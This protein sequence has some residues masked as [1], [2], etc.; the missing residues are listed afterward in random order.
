ML[1]SIIIPVY[2]AEKYLEECLNSFYQQDIPQ[3]EYEVICVND[4][5]T[6]GSSIILDEFALKYTNLKIINKDNGGVASSRNEGLLSARGKYVW[7]VDA[8]DFIAPNTLGAIKNA[9]TTDKYD[10]IFVQSYCFVSNLNEHEK[11][12]LKL[13]T[14]KS[15]YPHKDTQVTRTVIKREI[16]E[17]NSIRFYTNLYYG[18]DT[19]FYFES[20][21]GKC[22]D[23]SLKQLIYFY[24]KHEG[25][26]TSFNTIEKL[27]KYLYSCC[28]AINIVN[29][30]YRIKKYRNKAKKMLTYWFDTMFW[31]LSEYEDLRKIKCL[32]ALSVDIDIYSYKLRRKYQL[33]NMANISHD[34]S[35]IKKEYEFVKKKKEKKEA[36]NK[37]IKKML[38]YIKHPKKLLKIIKNSI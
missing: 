16:I 10:R 17:S 1:L 20:G 7:F 6:D 38:V 3:L 8:D 28:C 14:L 21:L 11:K 26:S 18:E 29:D 15:N 30:Y 12:C 34:F 2:N 35:I 13:G 36:I 23:H 22:L 5:S 9:I 19:M 32:D 24:R 33:L 4:G 25:A 27:N 37:L 31:L